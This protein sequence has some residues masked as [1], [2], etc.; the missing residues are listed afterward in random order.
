MMTE[1]NK[2]QPI[3]TAKG[4]LVC[5]VVTF[6]G[7]VV[8]MN[9]FKVPPIQRD[10]MSV[11]QIDAG[12][13][14]W[15]TSVF[16]LAGLILAVP[17]AFI[18]RGTGPKKTA[19]IAL[20]ATV[21]GVTIGAATDKFSVLLVS[22]VIEGTGVALIGVV[23]PSVIAMYFDRAKSGLPMGI[24]NI[25]YATGSFT[26]YNVAVPMATKFSGGALNWHNVWWFGD[27]MAL[28][29]FLLVAFF[30]SKP[31]PQDVVGSPSRPLNKP[32]NAPS[33]AKLSDGFKVRRV[34]VL[35]VGFCFL[36]LTSLSF[37]TW[38][39][40]YFREAFGWNPAVAGSMSSLGYVTS[41]PASLVCGLL[42]AKFNTIKQRNTMLVLCAVIEL[43]IYPWCFFIPESFMSTYLV[44]AGLATGFTAGCVW[45]AVPLTMP[46]KATIPLGMGLL[47]AFKSLANML[48]TPL[49][50]YVVQVGG[51]PD[52]PVFDWSRGCLPIALFAI[53]SI[54]CMVTYAKM[55][56][57]AFEEDTRYGSGAVHHPMANSKIPEGIH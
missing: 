7:I 3:G 24:W 53:C 39:P 44:L 21:I 19:M 31:R 9:Q 12:A 47:Q 25:W 5:L 42:L 22:R 33:K 6:A 28:I 2:K 49:M 23:G 1:H 27:I 32:M 55:K 46:I 10:L 57:D 11:F 14:G 13:A 16:A 8:M 37:L 54:I 45:A 26:A 30:V 40:T 48:G 38:A 56:P 20:G 15:L 41:I 29:A 50:G 17:A 52:K 18:L 35:A 36:M 4:W 51:T 34:W 43:A